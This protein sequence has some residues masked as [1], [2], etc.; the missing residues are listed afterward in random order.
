MELWFCSKSKLADPKQLDTNL[1]ICSVVVEPTDSVLDLGVILD[2]KLSVR[3][4]VGNLSS[5]CFFTSI[6]CTSSG[7]CSTH[8]RNNAFLHSSYHASTSAMP[9]LRPVS[10]NACTS[11]ACIECS[12]AIRRRSASARSL[13]RYHAVATLATGSLS[14]S[15][16]ALSCDVCCLQWH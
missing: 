1:N 12:S 3:R 10:L 13:H 6:A 16:Q 9:C 2:S 4:H 14:D 7:G 5:I 15:L 8:R 11:S